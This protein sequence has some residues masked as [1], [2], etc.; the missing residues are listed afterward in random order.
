MEIHVASDSPEKQDMVLKKSQAQYTLSSRLS[1][2]PSL[3]D[4]EDPVYPS[5]LF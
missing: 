3:V 4:S 2:G 1:L 5:C